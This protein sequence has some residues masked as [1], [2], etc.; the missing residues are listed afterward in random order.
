MPSPT[1]PGGLEFLEPLL[2]KKSPGW[3]Q[4]DPRKC[5]EPDRA[6]NGVRSACFRLSHPSLPPPPASEIAAGP[7]S[8]PKL[9]HEPQVWPGDT[10][11]VVAVEPAVDSMDI[12]GGREQGGD[13]SGQAYSQPSSCPRHTHP[14]CS[15]CLGKEQRPQVSVREKDK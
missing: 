10:A 14:S 3:S 1:V 2:S 15:F 11:G 8:F 7:Q 13:R 12:Y 9:A 6:G 5:G 4:R